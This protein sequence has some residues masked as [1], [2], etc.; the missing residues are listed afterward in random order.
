M[1]AYN[2]TTIIVASAALVTALFSASAAGAKDYYV[3]VPPAGNDAD[4]GTMDAP[5]ASIAKAQSVAAPGDTV[6][7]KDGTYSYTAGVNTCTSQT[8]TVNAIVLNKS[9]T[10]GNLIHYVAAAG[11]TPVFDFSKMKDDCRVKAFDVT[12]SYIHI[13]GLTVTGAPQNND[14]NH[15]SWGVWNSGS[16]NVFEQID[17]H[18]NMGPGIFI[19]NGA[20]NLVLNC[21]SHH[22]YDPMTSNGAGQSADGF[23]CHI[24]AGNKGNVFRGCRAWWNSD[25]GYDF[26][27]ADEV[28]TIENSWAWYHGYLPDTMTSVSAGNGNGIKAGGYG[29]TYVANAPQHVV[30]NC[31]SVFNKSAGFYANH[32]PDS[33]IFYNNTSYSNN[34]DFNMLGIDSGGGSSTVGVY[35]NNI[36][37]AGSL[38]S[39]R[40][41]AD[42][43]SNSWT[44]MGVTVST[45]DFQNVAVTGLDAPRQPDGSLPVLP[46]FHLAAGSDLVDKGVDVGLPHAGSAPDLGCFETGLVTAGTGGTMST[47][48]TAGT[49]GATSSGGANAGGTSSGGAGNADT[50]GATVSAGGMTTS[51]SMGGVTS[52][53]SGAGGTTAAGAPTSSAGATPNGAG[54]SIGSGQ[55]G[56]SGVPTSSSGAAGATEGD[57][58]KDS[59]G[60]GCTLPHRSGETGASLTSLL[61]LALAFRRRVARRARSLESLD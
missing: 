37:L 18:H 49:G 54:A 27:N 44:I 34:P 14:K 42:E 36:A 52:G 58:S 5:F 45:A 39:N 3:A 7:F 13:K 59:S 1:K 60:C 61:L 23:G 11:A 6:Y 28:C 38:F 21:D 10:A 32:H 16:N 26:I 46:N 30:R 48:G 12:G 9:G 4:A 22:N 2:P 47:G 33:P 41:N 19:Q 40:T 29:A 15:E 53:R 20:N 43:A 57:S 25:D 56:G 8:D 24:S 55:G 35:R 50:G 17:A 31:L 51:S